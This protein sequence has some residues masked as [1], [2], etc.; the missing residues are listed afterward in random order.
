MA[1]SNSGLVT[2]TNFHHKHYTDHRTAIKGVILHHMGGKMTGKACADYFATTTRDVSANYCIG[3]DG[4][5]ACSVP[6][7]YRAWTTNG[8]AQDG[9]YVTIE[10][11]NLEKKNYTV[12]DATIRATIKLIA[13]IYQ[14]NGIKEC[15]FTGKKAGSNLMAHRWYVETD[16]PGDFL[17]AK[18]GYIAAEVNKIL[19]GETAKDD[20]KPSL[21]D[22]KGMYMVQSGA[23]SKKANATTQANKLKKAG[24]DAVVK[25]ANDINGDGALDIQDARALLQKVTTGKVEKATKPGTPTGK[26]LYIVQCGVFSV[27]GNATALANKLKKAGF[28]AVVKLVDDVDGDGDVD[29]DDAEALIKKTIG[30]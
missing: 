15:L 7:W 5:I 26:E 24:F 10:V 8:Y 19:N 14:R 11:S 25:V 6:E 12:S 30:K 13:D 23:F 28:D 18:F 16:C 4:D 2:Y 29:K 17:Y 20:T 27:K 3:Y 9:Y 22:G 1:Y 21:S